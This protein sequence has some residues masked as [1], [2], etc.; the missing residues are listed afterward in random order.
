MKIYILHVWL[1]DGVG[2]DITE[3]NL[4][5]YVTNT[6]AGDMKI[7]LILIKVAFIFPECRLPTILYCIK[8]NAICQTKFNDHFPILLYREFSNN[9]PE[10]RKF[11]EKFS[12]M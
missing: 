8:F 7:R 3:Q 1:L 2:Q 4:Y 11:P 12:Y 10:I 9:Y 6:T 5:M